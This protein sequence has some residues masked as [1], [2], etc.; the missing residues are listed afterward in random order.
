MLFKFIFVIDFIHNGD[1]SA[2]AIVI[3]ESTQLQVA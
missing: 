1:E 3:H 2:S